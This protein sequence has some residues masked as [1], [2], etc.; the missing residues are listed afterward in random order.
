[1]SVTTSLTVSTL[2]AVSALEKAPWQSKSVERGRSH[3][4]SAEVD[5]EQ[6]ESVAAVP[7]MLV[8]LGTG[9]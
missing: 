3:G 1:M 7:L 5:A 6:G 2:A 4:R 9:I 8:L